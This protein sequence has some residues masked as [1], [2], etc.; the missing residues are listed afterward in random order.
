MTVALLL[1][2]IDQL[3][4]F[5]LTGLVSVINQLLILRFEEL[6]VA[7]RQFDANELF[8]LVHFRIAIVFAQPVILQGVIW[9]LAGM[10]GSALWVGKRSI[11]CVS[12]SIVVSPL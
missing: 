3:F 7:L 2:H 12:C 6:K 10:H 5:S 1:K 4:D 9:A 8:G 11:I